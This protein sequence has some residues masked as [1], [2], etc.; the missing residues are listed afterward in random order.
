MTGDELTPPALSAEALADL[1]A[2][3]DG[4]RF[5]TTGPL[6]IALVVV[7]RARGRDMPL[8]AFDFRAANSAQVAGAGGVAAN[9]I[10]RRHGVTNSL[11]S[12]GGR[13]SRGSIDRM[14]EL[15]ALLNRRHAAGDL[16]LDA[17]EA[18]WVQKARDYFNTTP[19]AFRADPALSLR[20]ALRELLAQA[21]LRQ[22]SM[23]G[24][25]IVGAVMQHIVGAVLELSLGQGG[26]THHGSNQNDAKGRGG[27]FELEDAVLHVTNAPTAQLIGKCRANLDAG[28]RPVIITNPK[29]LIAAEVLADAEGLGGRIEFVDFEQFVCVQLYSLGGFKALDVR[30][31]LTRLIEIYNA[32]IDQVEPSPSLRVALGG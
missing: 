4:G 14:E 23:G 6:A 21:E 1:E 17:V 18:F 27:D 5:A 22:K 2:L 10:L 30:S 29:P 19:I 15:V 9:R 11:G 16:D 8:D 13:T 3:V 26:V 7:D 12:E 32:I 20:M 25:M 28:G 31:Q 24:V